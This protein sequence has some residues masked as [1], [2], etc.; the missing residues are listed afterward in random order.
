VACDLPLV[1]AGLL[2][3]LLQLAL[4]SPAQVL[5]PCDPGGRPQPLCAVYHRRALR[6]I[7]TRFTSGVRAVKEALSGLIVERVTIAEAELFQNVNT[8]QDWAAYDAK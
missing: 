7:E 6:E 4:A 3:R 8:P 5:L 2:T 1:H